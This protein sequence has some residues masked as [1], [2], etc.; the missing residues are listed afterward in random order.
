MKRTLLAPVAVFLGIIGA[1]VLMA[2]SD[3]FMPLIQFIHTGNITPLQAVGCLFFSAAG[4]AACYF[5]LQILCGYFVPRI[6][7][8]GGNQSTQTVGG[9]SNN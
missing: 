4:F 3:I 7:S 2:R 8:C 9:E 1:L 5:L 6:Q